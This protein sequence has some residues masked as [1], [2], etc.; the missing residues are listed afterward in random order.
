LATNQISM[1]VGPGHPQQRREDRPVE[2]ALRARGVAG[3]RRRGGSALVQRGVRHRAR[4]PPE[5]HTPDRSLPTLSRRI[6]RGGDLSLFIIQV[7]EPQ[8]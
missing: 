7:T 8:G 2:Q 3:G 5:M 6:D 4:P 1:R